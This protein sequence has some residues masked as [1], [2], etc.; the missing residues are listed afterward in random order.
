MAVAIPIIKGQK[1]THWT[2]IEEV[3]PKMMGKKILKPVRMVKVQCDCGTIKD[4]PFHSVR[5][6]QSKSCGCD[7]YRQ[8]YQKHGHTSGNVVSVE[9]KTW[10]SIVGRINNPNNNSYHNYGGRGIKMDARWDIKQGGSFENFLEDMGERPSSNHTFERVDVNGHYTK[11]NCVWETWGTQARNKRTPKVNRTGVRGVSWR[12]DTLK[13]YMEFR[14]RNGKR[15]RESHT[16]LTTAYERRLELEKEDGAYSDP[17]LSYECVCKYLKEN[18]PD[19]PDSAYLGTPDKRGDELEFKPSSTNT[20]GVKG[21]YYDNNNKKWRCEY[22][23]KSGSRKYLGMYETFELA[24]EALENYKKA[25][26][27]HPTH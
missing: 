9:Y 14:S 23:P 1:F 17:Q 24:K 6:G 13:W 3:E 15:I 18:R 22:R 12:K 16:H 19:I 10:Y 8:K 5:N 2:I 21:V 27:T 7:K 26:D 25:L 11:D 4:I 20:T